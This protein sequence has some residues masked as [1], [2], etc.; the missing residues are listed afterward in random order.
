[1]LPYLSVI[2]SVRNERKMLPGLID[3]LLE[4][5]YPVELYEILVVDGRSTDG[6]GET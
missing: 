1:M 3:Q 2:V 5:N 4:Q 6:Y